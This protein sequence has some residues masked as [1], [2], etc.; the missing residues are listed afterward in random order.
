MSEGAGYIEGVRI[1]SGWLKT[2]GSGVSESCCQLVVS[3]VRVL[4]EIGSEL[5]LSGRAGGCQPRDLLCR[6]RGS[7][8]D[9]EMMGSSLRKTCPRALSIH[10]CRKNR[11][12]PPSYVTLNTHQQRPVNVLGFEYYHFSLEME[13]NEMLWPPCKKNW[14]RD[15]VLGISWAC[16]SPRRWRTK[17]LE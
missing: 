12:T 14:E 8:R 10:L 11:R 17:D 5:V 1:T 13:W 7:Q 6:T 16:L 9:R 3:P 15:H 2:R 4:K